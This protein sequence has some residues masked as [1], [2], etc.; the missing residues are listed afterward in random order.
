M[1]AD[2]ERGASTRQLSKIL[3]KFGAQTGLSRGSSSDQADREVAGEYL[4]VLS[5]RWITVTRFGYGYDRLALI[6]NDPIGPALD[7]T[8]YGSFG[9]TPQF[10]STQRDRILDAQHWCVRLQEE[11]E[12]VPLKSPLDGK[13]LMAMFD[14]GPG[15]WLRPIKEHLLG[16]VIDGALAPD[17][18]EGAA[19]IA[20][21][22]V[23]REDS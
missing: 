18:K 21:M 13:E 4:R 15:P 14:R 2:E 6:P 23:E 3:P 8:G 12:R 11:A 7:I 5:P 17:D 22:L 10:P 20:R 19:N 1:R 16:L 9:R